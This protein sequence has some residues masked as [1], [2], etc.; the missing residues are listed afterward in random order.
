MHHFYSGASF[1][2]I[3]L[4][5]E[6]ENIY[7]PYSIV[8]LILSIPDL[9]PLSDFEKRQMTLNLMNSLL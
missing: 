5:V 7:N 8:T 9:C 4:L 2:R 6:K 3:H 1:G